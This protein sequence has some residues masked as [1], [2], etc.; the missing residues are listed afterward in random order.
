MKFAEPGFNRLRA[1]P[2]GDRRRNV[3]IPDSNSRDLAQEHVR[4][5]DHVV[6][7][8]LGSETVILNLHTGS[9]HGLNSSAGRMLEVLK[10]RGSLHLAVAQVAEEYG[11]PYER[12]KR[13]LT[14]LCDG[15]VERGLIEIDR[16][17]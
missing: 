10:E 2:A 9:Y 11:E 17:A 14:E 3:D 5:P 8:S 6:F 16:R 1:R 4:V 12:I 7:R 15:L 13:D